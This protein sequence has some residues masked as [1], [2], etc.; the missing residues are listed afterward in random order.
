MYESGKKTRQ[1]SQDCERASNE[2]QTMTELLESRTSNSRRKIYNPLIRPPHLPPS[3]LTTHPQTD[4]PASR[5]LFS[6]PSPLTTPKQLHNS[7]QS[8]GLLITEPF[9]RVKRLLLGWRW[10]VRGKVGAMIVVWWCGA[11]IARGR[12]IGFWS[13]REMG[14]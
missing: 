3:P 4:K 12:G 7:N 2:I 8:A 13:K 11:G 6:H 9:E 5:G 1:A 10:E 14:L